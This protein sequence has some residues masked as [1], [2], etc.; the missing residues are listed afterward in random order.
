MHKKIFSGKK[1][2][3]PIIRLGSLKALHWAWGNTT[4]PY[5]AKK[6][7]VAIF[8]LIFLTPI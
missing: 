1:K 4:K 6:Y 7:K 8:F 3:N 5:Y 2:P